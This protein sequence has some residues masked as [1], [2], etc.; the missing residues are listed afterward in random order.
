LL[1]QKLDIQNRERQKITQEIQARA[2]QIALDDDPDA[3]LLF[4]RPAIVAHQGETHTRASCRSIPEFH[5][6][7]ALDRCEE[8]MDHHG[9]HAAAAGFTVR[10]E[11]LPELIERLRAIAE[12]ELSSLDL[13]PVLQADLEIQLSDLVPEILDRELKV[14]DHRLV[15]RDG[16]HLKLSVSD[17]WIT[18]DAIAFRQGHWHADMPLFIDLMYTFERNEYNGKESLQLKV[19]DIQPS[20]S[21]G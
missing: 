8:L 9:G 21:D 1:A 15:G 6:T 20:N 3:L 14:K 7:D 2:E 5:I 10:N 11:N 16:T 17:G 13:R 19:K 18:Y 12:Q 4:A